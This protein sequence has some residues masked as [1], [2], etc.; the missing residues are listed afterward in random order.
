MIGKCIWLT[1]KTYAIAVSVQ[2][3]KLYSIGTTTVSARVESVT[4]S[5]CS[6]MDTLPRQSVRI[7]QLVCGRQWVDRWDV[8]NYPIVRP[9]RGPHISGSRLSKKGEVM[10]ALIREYSPRGIAYPIDIDEF[11]VHYNK[12]TKTVSAD[13]ETIMK[14]LF[15]LPIS[16]VWS[17]TITAILHR[18]T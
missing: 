13:K 3:K 10:T 4:V 14:Y 6:R 1:M 7:R 18:C 5:K 16:T 17:I 9:K 15:S 2:N 8:G 11:V 12:S